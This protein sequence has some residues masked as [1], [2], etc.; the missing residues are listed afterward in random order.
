MYVGAAPASSATAAPTPTATQLDAFRA[1][2]HHMRLSSF[3]IP[4]NMSEV[5]QSDF[6]D[7]RQKSVG[8]EGMTQ[9]DLLFRMTAARCALSLDTHSAGHI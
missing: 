7:R 9:E 8:G 6:V 3:S 1:F 2:L 5:I 4:E